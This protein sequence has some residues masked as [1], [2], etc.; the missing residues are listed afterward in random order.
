MSDAHGATSST[1]LSITVT[2]GVDPPYINTI[3]THRF[4]TP[5]EPGDLSFINGFSYQDIDSFGDRDGQDHVS[6]IP[7]D[8]LN[9]T[10]GGGVTVSGIGSQL[11]SR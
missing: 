3:T 6:A 7:G 11:D 8:I 1:T 4:A 2:G 9:A 10:S 5:Q